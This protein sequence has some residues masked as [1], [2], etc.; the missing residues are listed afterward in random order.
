[1]ITNYKQ[2]KEEVLE[3]YQDFLA[4]VDEANFP[5]DNKSMIALKNQAENIRKDKF[6]LMIAGEAKSGKSTFINAFFR[7]R[8]IANG[9]QTMHKRYS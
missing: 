7:S 8:N 4:V 1:M 6:L 3:M 5:L 2:I 9:C